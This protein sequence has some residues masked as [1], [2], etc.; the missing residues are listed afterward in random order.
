MATKRKRRR[1]L[2]GLGWTAEQHEFQAR[3]HGRFAASDLNLVR[4]NLRVGN[5]G[6]A[7]LHLIAM[8][9]EVGARGSNEHAALDPDRKNRLMRNPTK[10]SQE[11]SW[12]LERLLKKMAR[13]INTCYVGR[14]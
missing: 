14:R 9:Q 12:A 6:D 2:H 8:A 5:C 3:Q 1:G 13:E 4:R 10:R 11:Q 7:M